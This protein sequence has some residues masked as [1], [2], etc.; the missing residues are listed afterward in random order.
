MACCGQGTDNAKVKKAREA[1]ENSNFFNSF[2][3][4]IIIILLSIVVY[5]IIPFVLAFIIFKRKK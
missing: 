2:F 3:G 5:P 1:Y 4:K